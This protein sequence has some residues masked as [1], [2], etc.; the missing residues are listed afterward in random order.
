MKISWKWTTICPSLPPHP[1]LSTTLRPGTRAVGYSPIRKPWEIATAHLVARTHLVHRFSN[2]FQHFLQCL[3][4][5]SSL[6]SSQHFPSIFPAFSGS[7]GTPVAP[8][9]AKA[10]VHRQ[11]RSPQG[12]PEPLA[13]QQLLSEAQEM[14]LRAPGDL[15]Q[16]SWKI[17]HLYYI[18]TYRYRYIDID[19]YRWV[20]LENPWFIGDFPAEN[21]NI[22]QLPSGKLA[23]CYGKSPSLS[24]VN[25]TNKWAMFNSELLNYQ[26][27]Y[28]HIS[29][30]VVSG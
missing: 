13:A 23:V 2:F 9:L 15:A 1:S 18:Y 27:V 7:F 3:Q 17:Y 22:L 16:R 20:C 5:V 21:Y 8:H 4:H 28:E 6:A 10:H 26:R 11:P 25:R 29:P 24:S 14:G 12:P 30:K 19:D